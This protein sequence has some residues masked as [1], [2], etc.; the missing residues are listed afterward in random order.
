MAAFCIPKKLA[1]K[2]Q[3][4]ARS[5]DVI[6]NMEK[7]FNM[8]SEERRNAF[9]KYVD[10][11]TAKE[12]NLGFEKA[13][14]A[15]QKKAWQSWAERTF[16]GKQK[17]TVQFKSVV[18]TINKMD[19]LLTPENSKQFL[20]DVVAEKLGIHVTPEQGKKISD[21]AKG[22][23]TAKAQFTRLGDATDNPKAQMD[24]FAQKRKMNDYILS[25]NPSHPLAVLTS[26]IARGNLLFRV[27]AVAMNI[28]GN[29]E[30]GVMTALERR[31]STGETS[32]F[33][34]SFANTQRK[35]MVD[36][37][38]KTGYD[39]TR[40]V[41]L[42]EGSKVRGENITHSQGKGLIPAVGRWFEDNIFGKT[43]GRPDVEFSA[44]A[45]VDRMNLEAT[46]MAKRE[47]LKGVAAKQRALQLAQDAA[48]LEPTT[49]QGMAIRKEAIADAAYSTLQHKTL[50]SDKALAM[51]EVL[52]VGDLKF[53]DMTIPFVKT[54]ANSI[55][56]AVFERTGIAIP[57][58][59]VQ[60]MV[61]AVKL[62][63]GDKSFMDFVKTQS[64]EMPMKDALQ[65]AFKGYS[66]TLIR[67]GIG[68][69]GAFLLVNAIN[70]D[71]FIGAYPTDPRERKLIELGNATPNSFKVGNHY[72]STDY[73]TGLAAP[74]LGFMYAKK[75]GSTLPKAIEAYARLAIYRVTTVPGATEFADLY[76]EA[77]KLLP[78]DQM[79]DPTNT[80]LNEFYHYVA[81]FA[82]TRSVPGLISQITSALDVKRDTSRKKDN[83]A[84]IK[85]QLPYF[86]Q[87]LPVK[88]NIF[89]ETMDNE[90]W[91][92]LLFGSRV[93]TAK[94]EPVVKELQ[95]LQSTGNIP[96]LTDISAS[97]TRAKQLRQQ[98]GDQ[99]YNH[100]VVDYGQAFK[101]GISDLLEDPDYQD[102]TDEEKKNMINDLKS[103]TFNDY[104]DEYGY[105]KPEK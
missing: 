71:D 102:A 77:N 78:S 2:L 45:H 10:K 47:G 38:K 59:A 44:L 3:E 55:H 72:I 7:L 15:N 69:T 6:G 41:G 67:G 11:S 80:V 24:Y 93:K 88:T 28:I 48:L 89:G 58:K 5:G 37:Y 85:A 25:L 34:G 23:E 53:G 92:T 30:Q 104:L 90:G 66:K 36:V 61:T 39:L 14:V 22:I 51:R 100:F 49:P 4:A 9:G 13:M 63:Q 40:T 60:N 98:I 33:N 20:E 54:T 87:Q 84:D 26:T 31:I 76:N 81:N 21:L 75:Y 32:G 64:G 96:S 97:S 91:G 17:E 27:S 57:V 18:D 56:V 16:V 101:Q 79:K 12:I 94:D 50:F 70:P 8:S 99:E 42:D 46:K 1:D 83:F 86:R 73:L 52:N 103:T 62:V 68:L 105:E 29:T 95:R 43:Q 74:F 65:L 19:T 35:F 82:V